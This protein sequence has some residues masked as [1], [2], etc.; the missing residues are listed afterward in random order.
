MVRIT[1]L[2]CVAV[3]CSLLFL[4]TPGRASAQELKDRHGNPLKIGLQLYS[5]RAD[6]AKDLDGTLKAIAKI[7]Y[8][9]VEFAGYYGKSATELKKMLADDGLQCYGSHVDLNSLT[10]DNLDKT[11]TFAQEL[12]CKSLI[13]PWLPEAKRNS[14]LTTIATAIQFTE[15]AKKAAAKGITIGWHNEDYEFQKFDGETLWQVFWAHAGKQVVMEFDTGN[16]M[17]A[18]EQAAPYL[19]KYPERIF[20]VHVKDHSASNPNALLGEGDEHWNEV[21]PI[22]KKKDSPKYFIIE[23][24]SYGEPPLVCVEKCLANFKKLWEKY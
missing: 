1:R 5:V 8:T 22:L 23:Q 4:Q 15:I 2:A 17:S 19:K 3:L 21:I 12:G 9:G 20:A 14:A 11:L 13:V 7:G 18:G 10:G 6:C 24:E 16:A